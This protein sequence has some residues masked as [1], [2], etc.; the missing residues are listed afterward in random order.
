VAACDWPINTDCVADWD[1]FDAPVQALATTASVS[2]LDRLTGF[3][4]SQCPVTVRPCG[5]P[6]GGFSG[7]MTWPVGQPGSSGSGSPW[8]I[9]FVDNGIWRNCGCSGGCSCEA[10]CEIVI[11]VPTVSVT[12]VTIDGIE[13]DSAAYRLDH[14]RRGAV[15]VRTDGECFPDCQDM[16]A[17]PADVGSFTVT[18]VPGAPLPADAAVYVGML[19]GQFARA[20]VGGDCVLPQELQSLSRNGVEVQLLDPNL[21]P[22]AILTGIASVDRWVRSVNPSSLRSRSRV[23]S[24]DVR[25]HRVIA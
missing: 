14:T 23:L 1:T 4:F 2:L 24:P 13:L 21:I 9:P 25:P 7:Y 6:C 16:D 12:E 15:L 19:A 10:S 3:Q 20:C 17:G 18:Y 11:G 8:M 5:K 22:E